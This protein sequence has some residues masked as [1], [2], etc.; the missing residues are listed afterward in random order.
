[1][2]GKQNERTGRGREK[3][4]ERRGGERERGRAM[5]RE[6]ILNISCSTKPADTPVEESQNDHDDK[7]NDDKE[8]MVCVAFYPSMDEEDVEASKLVVKDRYSLLPP[9]FP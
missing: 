7:G 8:L 1:M 4:G 6:G 3:E 5:E 2:R 9:P